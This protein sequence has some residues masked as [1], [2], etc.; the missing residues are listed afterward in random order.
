MKK[1]L[2]DFIYREVNSPI[3]KCVYTTVGELLWSPQGRIFFIKYFARHI[4]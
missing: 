4:K 3:D 2:T 1:K